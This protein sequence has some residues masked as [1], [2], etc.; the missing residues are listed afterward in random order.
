M[1]L[2]SLGYLG[3]DMH[4]YAHRLTGFSPKTVKGE[5][6]QLIFDVY[7]NHFL[8]GLLANET[9]AISLNKP[10]PSLIKL[11][12][13]QMSLINDFHVINKQLGLIDSL[14]KNYRHHYRQEVQDIS[15][16]RKHLVKILDSLNDFIY[17]QWS[18][19]NGHDQRL[20]NQKVQDLEDFLKARERRTTNKSHLSNLVSDL[21]DNWLHMN[22][23]KDVINYSQYLVLKTFSYLSELE[24]S[25]RSKTIQEFM[26]QN[27]YFNMDL[28]QKALAIG[29]P[30]E[31][32]LLTYKGWQEMQKQNPGLDYNKVLEE[33]LS[34]SKVKSL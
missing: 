13:A 3:S 23:T 17:N 1:G 22:Q 15:R 20:I 14:P 21:S 29:T 31:K 32:T 28:F 7:Y 18:F 19:P 24:P 5:V 26:N 10:N 6:S 9:L 27:G 33:A 34:K 2:R 16:E 12:C 4:D 25:S 11:A 30:N 8:R